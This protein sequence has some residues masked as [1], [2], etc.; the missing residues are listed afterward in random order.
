[1]T[2]SHAVAHHIRGHYSQPPLQK[3]W[4]DI[5]P[6]ETSIREAMEEEYGCPSCAF[7]LAKKV[8]LRTS[9]ILAP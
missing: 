9:A 1:M 8:A 2:N 4:D 3:H 5:S 6:S 7:R